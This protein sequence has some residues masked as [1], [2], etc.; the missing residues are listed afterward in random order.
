M[1]KT[2]QQE[3]ERWLRR[4][5]AFARAN[6]IDCKKVSYEGAGHLV[7]FAEDHNGFVPMLVRL[8]TSGKV[9]DIMFHNGADRRENW[10]EAKQYIIEHYGEEALLQQIKKKPGISVT[11]ANGFGEHMPWALPWT[12]DDP[13]DTPNRQALTVRSASFRPIACVTKRASEDTE[14]L[15]RLI[16]F[17]PEMYLLLKRIAAQ[18]GP[19]PESYRANCAA[20][21]DEIEGKENEE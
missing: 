17:A 8:T 19:A 4:V 6:R 11:F 15:A 12:I 21:I 14:A 2:A 7:I 20:I 10:T 3:I 13:H 5:R 16:A 9:L 18:D 1:T